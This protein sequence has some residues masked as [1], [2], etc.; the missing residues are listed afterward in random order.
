MRSPYLDNDVVRTA[1]RAPNGT[2]V[3]SDLFEDSR[4]CSRLIADGNKKLEEVPTDRGLG[5]QPDRWSKPIERTFQEF[6]FRAEYAYDYGMPQWLARIDHSLAPL[7]LERLFLGRHKFCHFRVW[8]RDALSNYV[9]D[10]LLDSR[11]LARPYLDGKTLQAIVQG[12]TREGRNY[13]TELHKL[14]TLELLH[15]LFLDAR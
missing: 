11:S 6:T 10:I 12:H 4:E 5:G 7:H 13:T 15:R 8:Y 3:K 2:M 14:L 9:R 1:F